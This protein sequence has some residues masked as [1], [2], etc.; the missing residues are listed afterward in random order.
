MK[1]KTLGRLAGAYD[2]FVG[3][4][5]GSMCAYFLSTRQDIPSFFIPGLSISYDVVE[6]GMKLGLGFG[7]L[8]SSFVIAD[9]LTDVVKGTHHYFG[10]KVWQ[11]LTR[12]PETKRRIQ[13][14]LE[15]QLMVI[16]QDIK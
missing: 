1:L 4:V 7:I 14:E 12:N 9:G 11:K 6:A 15:E 10:C 13:S 2:A 3:S 16:E 5:T 8:A